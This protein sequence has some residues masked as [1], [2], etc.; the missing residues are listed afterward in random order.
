MLN[1]Y[2][3]LIL[4]TMLGLSTLAFSG[5]GASAA[6]ML[7]LSPP[8]SGEAKA[9]NDGIIQVKLEKNRH[10]KRFSYH[11]YDGWY[12]GC[13]NF[14]RNNHFDRSYRNNHF[15]RSYLYLPLIIGGGYGAYDYY[16]DDYYDG[17]YGYAGGSSKHVRWCLKRYRSYN[18]RTNLWVSYSGRKHQCDSPYY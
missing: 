18:P 16:D 11:C 8:A 13:R 1:K 12:G 15:D 10:K 17:D 4:G 14:R 9:V 2:S 6:A 3:T 5:A 7:P